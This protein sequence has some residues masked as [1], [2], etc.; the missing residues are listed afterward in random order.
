MYH[1][2]ELLHFVFIGPLMQSGSTAL[3]VASAFGQTDV[4]RVLITRGATVD[5]KNK[6]RLNL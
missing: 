3:R 4:V 6:V 5:I 2:I 1:H